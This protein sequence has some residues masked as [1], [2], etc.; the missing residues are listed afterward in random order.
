MSELP[1][2]WD[3]PEPDPSPELGE[4]SARPSRKFP[5][6]PAAFAAGGL[7]VGVL[8]TIVIGSSG[9][10][11]KGAPVA[12]AV[13]PTS[14]S[15]SRSIESFAAAAPRTTAHG[16]KKPS[17]T[18][19]T[20]STASAASTASPAPVM[21]ATLPPADE[22]GLSRSVPTAVE[23]P[24]I[25]VSS[26]LV[27]LGLQGDG[28]L[29][30]PTDFSKAG[31]Y[32]SGAYPGQADE[33]PALIVGHVDNYKGPAIFFRLKELGVGDRVRVPRAD[34]TTATFVV[35]RTANYVKT[36]FPAQSVYAA[37]GRPE[38]RL[39]TCT[40]QFDSNARS[41]LSNFVVYAYL[42]MGSS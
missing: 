39:I 2:I 17:S 19:S 34:G 6:M 11:H 16:Q 35:Y 26:T 36:S 32:A 18:A 7:A 14:S 1:P 4:S 28:S 37:T 3:Q 30:V 8:V 27:S 5:V 31:W 21:P 12:A 20:A 23:I 25:G 24:K 10:T 13:A 33:P 22:T 42:E 40:G 38:L 9:G 41:Y 29:Q 15:V